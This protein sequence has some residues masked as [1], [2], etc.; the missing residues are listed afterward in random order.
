MFKSKTNK[1]ENVINEIHKIHSVPTHGAVQKIKVLEEK[2]NT[3]KTEQVPEYYDATLECV[4]IPTD[5]PIGSYI[6]IVPTLF[7]TV[8]R[9]RGLYMIRGAED[10]IST[11]GIFKTTITLFRY[12]SLGTYMTIGNTYTAGGIDVK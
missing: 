8:S 12:S 6:E 10:T 2:L 5:F 3:I 1:R 11:N 4:G 7:Q 9:T